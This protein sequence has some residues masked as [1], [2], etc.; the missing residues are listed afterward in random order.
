MTRPIEENDLHAFADGQLDAPRRAEV[1]AFLDENPKAAERVEDYRH[2]TALLHALFDPALEEPS[3]AAIDALTAGLAVRLSDGRLHRSTGWRRPAV[4]IA[5]SLLLVAVGLGGG[6]LLRGPAGGRQ[7]GHSAGLQTFAEEA[8]QAHAFYASDQQAPGQ[9]GAQDRGALDG[10]LSQRLGRPVT[11]P[12]LSQAGYRLVGGRPLPTPYGAGAQY[13]YENGAKQR[14]TLFV[15]AVPSGQEAPPFSFAQQGSDTML[16]WMEGSLGY[17]LIGR[18]NR[19]QLMGISRIA[20][21]AL[22]KIPSPQQQPASPQGG[23]VQPVAQPTA[24]VQ[25]KAM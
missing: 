13:L 4:R 24:P 16:Y 22:K 21:N 2:Q 12:D 17:A 11:A 25:G 8:A 7:P 5:A 18:M 19:D 15:S 6:Y 20:D 9:I 1:Q 14:L 3:N 23:A 10:W